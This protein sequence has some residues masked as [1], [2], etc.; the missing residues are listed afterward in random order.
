MKK[1]GILTFHYSNNFGGVLQC[2]ALQSFLDSKGYE[3][4]IINYIP[5]SAKKQSILHS[6]GIRKNVFKSEKADLMPATLIRR[7]AIKAKYN[8]KI[9]EKFN[10]FRESYMNLSEEVNE[11]TINS[12]LCKY[13][14][15][16]VGSDQ[17]WNPGRRKQRNYFLD[18]GESFKG[19]K[20]S[21]AADS[22]ISEVNNSH[23]DHLSKA[24]QEFHKISVRNDHSNLFVKNLI[25]NYAPVVCDPTLLL[26]FSELENKRKQRFNLDEKFILVYALGKEIDGS[27]KRLI[28]KIKEKYGDLKVYSIVI[29]TMKFNIP[30]Y[31][32]KVLYDLDPIEWLE[33]FRKAT[34]IMT[35]SFHGTL[36]SLKFHKPFIAYYAE[37]LRSTRFIDL[38][39]RYDI[40]DFIVST[41][42]DVDMK[43]SLYKTPDYNRVDNLIH[44]QKKVSMAF[45]ENALKDN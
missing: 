14:S 33:L 19:K 27:N 22:T 10:E 1:I 8:K 28:N 40:E 17:V 11:N 41:I 25:G 7:I 9:T 4:E 12:I 44:E 5:L 15:I 18:F 34:F 6:T 20:I 29:P 43:N 16:I 32:D 31:A 26:D 38:G 35:D 37:T 42:E 30:N 36:F 24:L 45:L 3:V 23:V 21:Y 2:Y 39:K 13:E